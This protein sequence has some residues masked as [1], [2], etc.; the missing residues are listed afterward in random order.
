[1]IK[2]KNL[3]HPAA[4][5][6]WV[7]F[8]LHGEAQSNKYPQGYF[9][10]PLTIPVSLTANFGELRPNHWHMGLDIRTEQKENYPVL[11]S[12]PG[13]VSHIGIRPL[14]FGKFIIIRHPNGYSTLYAHL[15]EFF[16]ALE[17][18][19]REK[20]SEKESW[21][22]E[23]DFAENGFTVNKGDTIAK[24]GNTGGSQGPHLHFE[25]LDTRSG[26]SLN[27]LLFGFGL[28]DDLPPSFSLLAIY[29]RDI[30][31]HLQVPQLIKIQ[32]T[33][34]GYFTR[35]R[36]IVTGF[37]KLSFAIGASDRIS[38]S[39]GSEGIYS[40]TL[41]FKDEPQ[42]LFILDS[43]NYAES[44]YINAHVDKKYRNSGGPYVQHLSKLPGFR[45]RVYEELDGNGIIELKDTS[46]YPVA[47][48]IFDTEENFSSLFLQIQYSDSLAKKIKP[49]VF[50]RILP[51]N[52]VSIVEESEFEAYLPETS[53]YDS[54]PYIYYR[55]NS[56][57]S[58]SV[59][60][61]HRFGD[62]VY[63]VHTNFSVRI[64]LLN[65]LDDKLKDKLII[66]REWEKERSVRKA[67]WQ[68][69]WLAASFGDFGN[70][71]AFVDTVAPTINPP[72]KERDTLDLSP[73]T[74]IIFSPKDNFAV[75]SF[76][77][78]L[79]GKWLMFSN[80]KG[81]DYVYIFDEQ[82]PYGVHHLKIKV[83]DIA[84]NILEKEWWFKRNPYTPPP[85]KKIYK[86]KTPIKK[87]VTKKT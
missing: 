26:R 46:V 1:M 57:S 14:S 17:K 65:P 71:Q 19:V 41:Y 5:C 22:I 81:R 83:E 58:G 29:N 28:K 82:C 32:K 44:D 53:L 50:K 34:S 72:A 37:K 51:P 42:L 24:S 13:Y 30:S 10:N 23:L 74:K 55:Q 78:E 86:K 20:Q 68:N 69:G 18:L 36:K 4:L 31:T 12:A 8:F 15:N 6:Y 25:I 45:G 73:L 2:G 79:N 39:T 85:K 62:P 3:R 77:A 61:Q 70:F 63:P 7:F 35:P 52:E 66:T 56:Y 40:S 21:A 11:A 80:D 9:A 64:K 48:E 27:P 60:S 75:K 16:P 47:I 43:M 49:P 84:G 87:P 33:D 76:R 38:G 54:I 67:E 59:T